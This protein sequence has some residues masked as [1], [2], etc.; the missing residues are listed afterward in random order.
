MELTQMEVADAVVLRI[1]GKLMGGPDAALLNEKLH[2]LSD[3]GKTKVVVDLSE[4]DMMNSTGLGLLIGGRT[5]MQNQGGD[6]KLA[7]LSERLRTLLT[8]SKLNTVFE[9]FD[10]VDAAVASFSS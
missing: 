2:E 7:N 10:D 4:V 3:A 9:I 5:I 8:I 6:L 1:S